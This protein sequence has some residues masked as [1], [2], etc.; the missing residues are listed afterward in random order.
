MPTKHK[1][2]KKSRHGMVSVKL[3]N[4]EKALENFNR[5][6]KIAEV[7]DDKAVQEAISKAIQDV[8][9]RIAESKFVCV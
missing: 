7:L 3:S 9:Y 1:S 8:N 2:N 4:D 5:A 6:L